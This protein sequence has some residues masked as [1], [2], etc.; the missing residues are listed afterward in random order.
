MGNSVRLALCQDAATALSFDA[1]ALVCIWKRQVKAFFSCLFSSAALFA[2]SVSQCFCDLAPIRELSQLLL[3]SIIFLLVW[4]Y[5]YLML[6]QGTSQCKG[7]SEERC[8][9]M[10]LGGLLAALSANS[11]LYGRNLS[12]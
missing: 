12:V 6:E 4:L 5:E 9:G 2:S 11:K 1:A 8:V 3:P 7:N 10:R